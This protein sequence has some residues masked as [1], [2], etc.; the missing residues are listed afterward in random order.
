MLPCMQPFLVPPPASR[1]GVFQHT[2]GYVMKLDLEVKVAVINRGAR[3]IGREIALALAAEGAAVARAVIIWTANIQSIAM[4]TASSTTISVEASQSSWVPRFSA[5]WS[6]PNATANSA[7]PMMSNRGS[8]CIIWAAT[9]RC[10]AGGAADRCYSVNAHGKGCRWSAGRPGHSTP[11]TDEEPP[12]HRPP[13][14]ANRPADP[15]DLPRS[16]A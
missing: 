1:S 9:S 6:E 5:S 13:R 7:K 15:T 11:A 14:C 4:K 8:G 12:P 3:D 2:L 16:P 10:C